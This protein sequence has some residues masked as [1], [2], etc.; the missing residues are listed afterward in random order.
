[1]ISLVRPDPDRYEDW[2]AAFDEF[3][4]TPKDGTGFKPSETV[5]TSP[6]AFGVYLDHRASQGDTS[7]APPEGLVHCTY[8]WILDDDVLVGF[9]ALR[10]RL[11]EALYTSGGHVGYSVRPSARGRGVATKALQLGL[12]EARRLGLE[13]VLVCCLETNAAS[14]SVIERCGGQF[15]DIREHGA[16]PG[17]ARRYWFGLP[18]WPDR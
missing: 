12:D 13:H 4:A 9:L 17:P 2:R 6:E 18:P 11:N 15:E 7:V 5:D 1:M 10:H 8:F 16:I 14:R 3:G